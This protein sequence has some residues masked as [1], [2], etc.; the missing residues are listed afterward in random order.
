[1]KSI[2]MAGPSITKL[3]KDTIAEMMESGWDNYEYVE[4]FESAFAMA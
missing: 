1:M 2:Q 3:E 4:K